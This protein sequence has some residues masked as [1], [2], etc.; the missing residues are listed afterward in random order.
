MTASMQAIRAA[1]TISVLSV[2]PLPEDHLALEG[3]FNGAGQG[4]GTRS[5]WQLFGTST[6]SSALNRLRQVPCPVVLCACDLPLG[7]WKDV[8]EHSRRL[9]NPPYLIVTARHADEYLWSEALNLGAYDVLGKPFHPDEVIRVVSMA[10]L[11]WRLERRHG[12]PGR[13]QAASAR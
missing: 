1:E 3:I 9:A 6:L 7:S 13:R 11:R 5:D 12:V 2:S 10:C 4:F 8:L